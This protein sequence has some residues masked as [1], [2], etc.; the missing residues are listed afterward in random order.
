MRFFAAKRRF[1]IGAAV[2]RRLKSPHEI[3][4]RGPDSVADVFQFEKVEATGARLIFAD[5]RLRAAERM[6]DI[7]LVKPSL[8]ANRPK[9]REQKLLL[10]PVGAA[11]SAA[12]LRH[13]PA[14]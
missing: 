8:L 2:Q 9:K 14:A 4:D 11:Q 1:A 7:R 12:S 6:S 10:P 13:E 3:A 5:E